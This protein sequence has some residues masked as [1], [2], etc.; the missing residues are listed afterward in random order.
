MHVEA[1]SE[2]LEVPVPEAV[3]LKV[4]FL[5]AL[6]NKESTNQ[7]RNHQDFTDFT[8][9]LAIER[10]KPA[11]PSPEM[12][13]LRLEMGMVSGSKIR[14]RIWGHLGQGVKL[15]NQLKF[16]FLLKIFSSRFRKI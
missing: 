14:K 1:V 4:I 3:K 15:K 12:Q 16:G 7:C 11:R 10:L 5:T 13:P 9:W 8:L 2:R 6:K